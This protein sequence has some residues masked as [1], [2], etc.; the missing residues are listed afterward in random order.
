MK[1]L[2]LLLYI[3]Q[4]EYRIGKLCQ[5]S[6]YDSELFKINKQCQGENYV[7]Q[8]VKLDSGETD[9]GELKLFSL[10]VFGFFCFRGFMVQDVQFLVFFLV[11]LVGES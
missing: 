6:D 7:V 1:Y 10:R 3:F 4:S 9:I 11:R 5:D 2:L 8:I